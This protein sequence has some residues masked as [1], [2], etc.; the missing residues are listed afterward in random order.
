[1]KKWKE[2][3][4]FQ[5]TFWV[6]LVFVLK[7]GPQLKASWYFLDCNETSQLSGQ[8]KTES[9]RG[10]RKD[11]WLPTLPAVFRKRSFNYFLLLRSDLHR[12]PPAEL[13]VLIRLSDLPLQAGHLG[14]A[15][16]KA[17]CSWSSPC[18]TI[19]FCPR[20]PLRLGFGHF[21]S[22]RTKAL[23]G[24]LSFCDIFFCLFQAVPVDWNTSP[25]FSWIQRSIVHSF[26][27]STPICW[28]STMFQTLCSYSSQESI[29]PILLLN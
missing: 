6:G 19:T 10:C 17:S 23:H 12:H 3:Y 25:S 18:Y 21:N 20:S 15:N 9:N 24:H 28:M 2:E 4:L 22:W 27:Y 8:P 1:M 16:Y 13:W 29:S 5:F 7:L 14:N 11:G 26:H